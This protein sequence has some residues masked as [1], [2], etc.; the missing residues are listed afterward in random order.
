MYP[1]KS[2]QN[3]GSGATVYGI[4]GLT[5]N[6]ITLVNGPTWG[7]GGLS[8]D[9]STQYAHTAGFLGTETQSW[10]L[11]RSGTA[12]GGSYM[13]AQWNFTANRRS[14]ALPTSTTTITRLEMF[15]SSDG[16]IANFENYRDNADSIGASEIMIDAQWISGGER[17]LRINGASRS[18]TLIAGSAQTGA[19][20]AGTDAILVGAAGTAASAAAH[21]AGTVQAVAFLQAAATTTQ[22]DAISSLISAL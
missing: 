5:A 4:G 13:L 1:M 15:R 12:A 6:N 2:A 8:F 22:R 10:F 20:N 17:N 18:Q 19:F 9:G 14:R 7:A 3:A 16:S 21:A 11:R